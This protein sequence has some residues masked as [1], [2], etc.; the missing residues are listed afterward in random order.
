[1]SIQSKDTNAGITIP[2]TRSYAVSATSSGRRAVI[3]RR[4][5]GPLGATTSR[6][7]GNR[8]MR[9]GRLRFS[10]KPRGFFESKLAE[11][12]HSA[13]NPAGLVWDRGADFGSEN[14]EA[15]NSR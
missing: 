11:A 6:E 8:T 13:S 2:D 4:L 10:V 14:I 12:R 9:S 15:Q 3:S 1:M 5:N 7:V